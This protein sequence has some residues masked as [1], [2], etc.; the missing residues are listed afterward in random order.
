M[1][2]RCDAC[3]EIACFTGVSSMRVLQATPRHRVKWQ[4][5]RRQ[6][7]GRTVARQLR[8]GRL[9]RNSHTPGARGE[10]ISRRCFGARGACLPVFRRACLEF[11][12]HLG[13]TRSSPTQAPSARPGPCRPAASARWINPSREA[14]KTERQLGWSLPWARVACSRE[15]GRRIRGSSGE[16]TLGGGPV[17]ACQAP[18]GTPCAGG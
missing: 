1:T 10:W 3:R 18:A 15:A 16:R 2:A 5:A 12:K 11:S 9:A 14:G 4:G 7:D 8:V 6:G 13:A 17:G